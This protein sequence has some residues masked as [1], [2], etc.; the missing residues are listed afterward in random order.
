MNENE[1]REAER[2]FAADKRLMAQA[3]ERRARADARRAARGAWVWAGVAMTVI[4]GAIVLFGYGTANSIGACIGCGLILLAAPVF[5]LPPLLIAAS[6][7]LKAWSL[8]RQAS[9]LELDR[10][11]SEERET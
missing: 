6:L 11:F 7:G 4:V 3:E 1:R 9:R 8:N 10:R 5:A 2:Q